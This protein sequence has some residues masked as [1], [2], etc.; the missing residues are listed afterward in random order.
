[1][2]PF[3]S[4]RSTPLLALALGC[5]GPSDT[6]DRWWPPTW[7]GTDDT[8]TDDTVPA[9][10]SEAPDDPPTYGTCWSDGPVSGDGWVA[11]LAEAE[12]QCFTTSRAEAGC[13][14]AV[15]F[16]ISD[17]D[18]WRFASFDASGA[19]VT[20]CWGTDMESSCAADPEVDFSSTFCAGSREVCAAEVVLQ[21]PACVGERTP[22]APTAGPPI[23]EEPDPGWYSGT[24]ESRIAW[25]G[26][27]ACYGLVACSGPEGEPR[28]VLRAAN[29]FSSRDRRFEVYDSVSGAYVAEWVEGDDLAACPAG[30]WRGPAQPA[31]LDQPLE[32]SAGCGIAELP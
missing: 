28:T 13:E 30:T 9:T 20:R 17:G 2:T 23:C 29:E 3:T 10:D 31:C 25:L 21:S 32:L 7:N 4:A 24:L 6:G 14:A 8:G 26:E 27:G 1:M 12:G 18:T 22:A 15:S 11:T 16:S 5:Q 19:P